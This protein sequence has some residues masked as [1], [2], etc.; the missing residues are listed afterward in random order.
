[1]HNISC[2]LQAAG[3]TTDDVVKC[4]V[5]LADIKDWPR[6]NA[7]YAEHFTGVR[8]ARTAVQSSLGFGIKVEAIAK[9]PNS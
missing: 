7:V 4:S 5:H 6:F 3:C 1:L 9:K 2:L 8:P